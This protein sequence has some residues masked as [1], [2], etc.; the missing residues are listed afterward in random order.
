MGVSEKRDPNR[1]P[2][3][4]GSLLK[5]PKIFGNSHVEGCC[6]GP[7]FGGFGVLEV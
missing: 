3:A 6:L 2:S 4:V 7:Q 5:G 1:V